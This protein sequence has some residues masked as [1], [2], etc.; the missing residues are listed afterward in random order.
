MKLS[1]A[2]ERGVTVLAL[3]V[4]ER[5]MILRALADAPA[6]LEELRATLLVGHEWRKRE[7]LM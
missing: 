5:E 1:Q 4:P 3:T 7:G 2:V 6:G